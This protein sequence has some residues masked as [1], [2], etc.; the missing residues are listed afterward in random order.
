MLNLLR[1]SNN[2]VW[3]EQSIFIIIIIRIELL[4]LNVYNLR[5]IL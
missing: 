2:P 5:L 1:D 3:I 4:I